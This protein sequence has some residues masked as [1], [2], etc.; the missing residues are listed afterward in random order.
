MIT[1]AD[2]SVDELASNVAIANSGDAPP[3]IPKPMLK[4]QENNVYL[5]FVGMF[6]IKKPGT[7]AA[8]KAVIKTI[9]ANEA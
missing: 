6:S 1:S 5:T 2:N 4:T 3:I 8:L 7:T 9:I